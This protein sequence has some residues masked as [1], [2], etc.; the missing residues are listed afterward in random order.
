MS[1]KKTIHGDGSNC[2]KAGKTNEGLTTVRKIFDE[3]FRQTLDLPIFE[4]C[5]VEQ[6]CNKQI[7]EAFALYL[8]T[9]K[10]KNGDPYACKS[11]LQYFSGFKNL[12]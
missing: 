12:V 6:S 3:G 11:L 1:S 7:F 10:K 2:F 9:M 8:K 5:S 4:H